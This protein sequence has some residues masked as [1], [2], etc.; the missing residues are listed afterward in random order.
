MTQSRLSIG[1]RLQRCTQ[2]VEDGDYQ[3][4]GERL[5][6]LDAEGHIDTEI[7]VLRAQLNKAVRQKTIA[8]LME[9]AHTRYEEQEDPLALRKIQEILQLDPQNVTALSLKDKIG[10]RGSAP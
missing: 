5:S 4:A 7:G 3:F 1:P 9:S 8:Q 6:E 2:A 10:T